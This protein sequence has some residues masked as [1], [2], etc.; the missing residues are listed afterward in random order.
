MAAIRRP[1]LLLLPLLLAGLA[2]TVVAVKGRESDTQFVVRQESL[3]S[4]PAS[5]LERFM[6]S[7][8]DPRPG[9]GGGKGTAAVCRAEG[10][11]QLRNPWSCV[12]RYPRGASIT[13]RV[14]VDPQGYVDGFS[15]VAK[16]RVYGCCLLRRSTE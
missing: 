12:V 14:T 11:G 7:A 2:A 4:I 5:L 6:I 3:S 8:H 15:R 9:L 1:A 16:V 13:Y 10:T